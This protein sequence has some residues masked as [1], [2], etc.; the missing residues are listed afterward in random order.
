[1]GVLNV[2]PDSFSD[3]GRYLDAD[4]AVAQGRALAE[5]GADL[6]DIGG[7]STR[8]GSEPVEEAEELRRVVPVVEALRDLGV[9]LSVDT[10]KA[11]V[12]EAAIRAG[13]S[14]V[15]DVSGLA[16]EPALADV[17]AAHPGVSLILGHTRGPPKTMQDG[18]IVYPDGVV[19]TVSAYLAEAKAKAM[20]AG[21][22]EDRIWVDPGFG[23]G[24]T[25]E[26]NLVLL[27]QLGR[28]RVLGPVVVGTSRKRFLGELTG[29]PIEARD[30]A[31]AA[32]V[33]LAIRE[34]A[35]MVRVHEV[36]GLVDVVRV[37]DAVVRTD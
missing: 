10:T 30:F 20:A 31:T 25:L 26:H 11:A 15:N 6:I 37:A 7:E 2:T 18:E 12:A 8:P 16:F 5:A 33:A 1:M 19:E 35:S 34:G 27:R 29:R 17:V 23:F 22:R 14:W 28:L 24:K 4:A 9:E 36:A 21:V 3:G 32:S 13:A